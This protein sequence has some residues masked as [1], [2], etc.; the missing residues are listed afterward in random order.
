MV[1]H[2]LLLA[3]CLV[4]PVSAWA[5]A[6]CALRDPVGAIASMYPDADSHQSIVRTI[7]PE[8]RDDIA[9]RLPFTLH[10]N[11]LGKHTLYVVQRAGRPL[12]FVHARSEPGRWGLV[13]LVWSLTPDLRVRDFRF[14]RCRAPNCASLEDPAF[15]NQLAGRDLDGLMEL[16]EP[17]G[18]A[19]RPGGIKVAEDA[20]E[21]ALAIVRSAAK[22]IAVTQSTW[23]DSVS[24]V[25][26]WQVARERFPV[27]VTLELV[28]E[29][30]PAAAVTALDKALAGGRTAILR[31][32][33]SAYRVLGP[34]GVYLGTVIDA[35]WTTAGQG[36]RFFWAFSKGGHVL[37]V[38]PLAAWPSNEA[39]SAFE[40]LVD[41]PI[42]STEN[43]S[44]A[45][46][47]VASEL[48]LLS[49]SIGNE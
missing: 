39:R 49:R 16:L 36:G 17:D 27:A 14:Q 11:E 30:Y 22:T 45:A 18:L 7:G 34:D 20:Q 44:G 26:A 19:L 42:P 25:Q 35:S 5:E 15:T 48:G 47:L 41:Q 8:V 10:F 31:D 21:L 32:T 2:S 9:G 37:G 40:R 23:P 4:L 3:A 28:P 24:R 12:G 43:C 46:E 1:A 13:E 6:Y 33:V 38:E 29:A